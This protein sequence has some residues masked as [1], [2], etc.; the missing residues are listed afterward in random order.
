MRNG[1]YI[2]QKEPAGMN[3]PGQIRVLWKK[4]P[5]EFPTG[6]V[7]VN[8]APRVIITRDFGLFKLSSPL[9]ASSYAP[10]FSPPSSL[11]TLHSSP[12]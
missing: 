11:K 9:R 10:S 2:V 7:H 5:L 3:E 4:E 1:P 6:L 8:H 12:F